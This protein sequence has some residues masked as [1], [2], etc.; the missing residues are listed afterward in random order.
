MEAIKYITIV[1]PVIFI[2]VIGI[3]CIWGKITTMRNK[4]KREEERLKEE[5]FQRARIA[6]A[7]EDGVREEKAWAEY[8]ESHAK[9]EKDMEEIKKDYEATRREIEVIRRGLGNGQ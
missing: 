6:K 2:V 1:E 4:R 5:E 8:R 9:Y 7:I 3:G